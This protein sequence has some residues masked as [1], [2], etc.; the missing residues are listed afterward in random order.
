MIAFDGVACARGGRTLFADLSFTVGA[1]DALL[2][3][4]PNGVGKSSLLRVAAGLLPPAAGRVTGAAQ[5]GWLGE[6]HA[7]DPELPLGRALGFWAA[8]DGVRMAAAQVGAQVRAAL[9]EAGL[10]HLSD[11]PVRLLSTGQ[12]RRAAL[13][14]MLVARP[15]VWLLDEPASGLDVAAVDRLGDIIARHRTG[16]GAVMIVSHQPV[17]LGDARALRL[18]A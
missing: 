15:P 17:A 3:S 4:G 5:R 14:P 18:G 9:V 7:L 8:V 12:K 11:V 2:I 6:A 16:G 10:D 1:G 13:V